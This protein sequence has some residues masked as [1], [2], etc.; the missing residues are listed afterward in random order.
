MERS[1][2]KTAHEHDKSVKEGDS[3]LALSQHQVMTGHLIEGVNVI[4]SEPRNMHRKVKESIH[5][6][7]NTT[8]G[9]YLPDLYL[10]LLRRP[11]GP[12]ETNSECLYSRNHFQYSCTP[13]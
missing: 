4:D 11:R 6:K 7:L 9:Y 2:G 12:G 5:I 10:P 8:G 13:C 1:L 3:K